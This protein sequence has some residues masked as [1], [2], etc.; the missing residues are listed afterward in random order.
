MRRIASSTIR[1]WH[2]WWPSGIAWSSSVTATHSR[3]QRNQLLRNHARTAFQR[4]ELQLVIFLEPLPI[5]RG[6]ARRL[7]TQA[8]AG[9]R[10][11]LTQQ[12]LAVLVLDLIAGLLHGH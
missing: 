3:S 7:V 5:P 4:L 11:A 2:N 8:R 12:D 1:S 6:H 10:I 9:L